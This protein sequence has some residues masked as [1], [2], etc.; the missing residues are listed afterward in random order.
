MKIYLLSF[1]LLSVTA[2]PLHVSVTEVDFDEKEKELEITMRIFVDDLEET[3]RN[4]HKQ[5]ELDLLGQPEKM[6][7][8]LMAPYLAARFQI[9][10]D[11]KLKKFNYLGH[12]RD[13]EAMVFYVQV[14]DV[15]KLKE[16]S[17][18]NEVITETHEDQS[19]L[20]HVTVAGKVKSLRLMR[21]TPS[22]TLS[23]DGK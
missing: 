20:V 1:F 21:N 2:H 4:F 11:G 14:S 16:V 15:R 13:G 22:G 12:E 7:D 23:F 18:R 9:S 19:N 17:V 5:P 10:V 6:T 3:L 8:Q